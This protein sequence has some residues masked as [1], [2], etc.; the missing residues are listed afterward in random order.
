MYRTRHSRKASSADVP[1]TRRASGTRRSP[2][3]IVHVLTLAF[4][5]FSMLSPLTVRTAFAQDAGT[6]ETVVV[7]PVAGETVIEEPA[8]PVE[9]APVVTDE[10]AAPAQEPVVVSEQPAAP[11]AEEAVVVEPVME[12][13]VDEPVVEGTSSVEVA[14]DPVEEIVTDPAAVSCVAANATAPWIASDLADY[15]PGALVTLTGAGWVP[16]QTVEIFVDDDGVADEWA[17]SW[18]HSTTVPADANG[19]VFY[20]FNLPDW[21]V[22]NYSVTA[23]GECSIANTTFTD[24]NS[25]VAISRTAGTTPSVYSNSVTFNATVSR[26]GGGTNSSQPT[27]GSVTFEVA[28]ESGISYH[29][30]Q[31]A[32]SSS[33]TYTTSSLPAGTYQIRA[34]YGGGG[35][36]SD[37]FSGSESPYIQ[38]VVD[39][40]PITVTAD[41]KTMTYGGTMPGLTYQVTTGALV[42][43][44]VLAGAL[45]VG[46]VTGKGTY[47][48]TQGTLSN[49]NYAITFVGANLVVAPAAITVTADAKTKVYGQA[50][51]ALTYKITSGALVSGDSLTGNLTRTGSSNVGTYAVQ[52]GTLDNSNYAITFVEADFT[53]IKATLTVV[54]D[55]KSKVYG[56]GDPEFTGTVTGLVGTDE[57]VYSRLAGEDVSTSGYVITAAVKG[58]AADNYT[59]AVTDGKLTITPRTVT[60]TPDSDQKKEQGTTD[61]T[62]MFTNDGGL[63]TTAFTGKLG[64]ATG[65][66]IG[67]YTITL[68]NLSA[69]PNYTLVLANDAPK[70]G[71]VAKS[72]TYTVS[73]FYQPL[74]MGGVEN[75]V[76]AGST[77][78]VKFR[79]T[80]NGTTTQFT[81]ATKVTV[82]IASTGC[83]SGATS[84]PIEETVTGTSGLRYDTTSG[85]FIYTY[86]TSKS[87]V[88]KCFTVQVIAVDGVPVVDGPTAIIKLK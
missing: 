39:A 63:A 44:D 5:V 84:D 88:G 76:K 32:G 11:V 45:S 33:V 52:Q 9:P 3:A 7:D 10:P 12:T 65:E 48:I 18:S 19:D 59:V 71:I 15:P 35:S 80:L 1:Q 54:V 66:D 46:P 81:D 56:Q 13:V 51:P 87:N 68:G 34:V 24:A 16:G 41:A 72:V 78:P 82:K 6:P 62:L 49:P 86:Q 67:T 47:A 29:E 40:K 83:M 60:I 50:D 23:T 55:S 64:R 70:F 77:I 38:Q 74:D 27:E 20:Q 73:N 69:G 61:P 42:G 30:V 36:R 17:G 8:A 4:F 21:Y 37:A 57:V 25:K 85:Q 26:D 14:V 53:I 79:I 31:L 43:T 2:Q 58:A 22:A 75:T 28:S